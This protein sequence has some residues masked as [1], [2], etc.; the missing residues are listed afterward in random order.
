MT[1]IRVVAVGKLKERFY[2]DACAEY[3]KRLGGYC[4]AEVIELPEKGIEKDA[5]EIRK[6]IP[7]GAYT[8][9]MC[10]EGEMLS[11]TE[12][13]SKLSALET[14]GRSRFC[15]VIG[16]SD[17]MSQEIKDQA[18]LCLSMSRMTFPHHFA[19]VMVLEQIYRAYSIMNNGKY[20]K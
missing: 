9:A 15:F 5:A 19:R 3:L 17:G 7:D 14:S 13:A 20:H 12:L 10:I 6:A 2:I 1:G 16:G 18:D 4:R 11:T 8:I